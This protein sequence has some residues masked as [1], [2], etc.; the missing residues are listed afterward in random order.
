LLH[1]R[2]SNAMCP[3]DAARASP[4]SRA[5]LRR[6]ASENHIWLRSA[7]ERPNDG[8][9]DKRSKFPDRVN[10]FPDPSRKFPVRWLRE[11]A[12]ETRGISG[13]PAHR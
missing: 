12:C 10:P 8:F 13:V 11:L 5:G 2:Q 1:W 7:P 3:R 4:R 6:A 9:P